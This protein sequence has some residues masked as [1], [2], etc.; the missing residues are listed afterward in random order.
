MAL[1]NEHYQP[2]GSGT[3]DLSLVNQFYRKG[4]LPMKL[5]FKKTR[6]WGP[7]AV[8]A[9]LLVVL[10]TP[11]ALAIPTTRYWVGPNPN[12]NWTTA[13][14]WSFTPPL[15]TPGAGQPVAGDD[16]FLTNTSSKTAKLNTTT[17]LLNSVTVDAVGGT[18]TLTQTY[19]PS[20]NLSASAETIGL[21]GIGVYNQNAG[22]N[23]VGSAAAENLLQPAR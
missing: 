5:A 8:I 15:G 10:L 4:E 1:F 13:N 22:N 9:A 3:W 17:P 7:L 14:N 21:N 23:T 6:Y 18:F 2:L 16:A 19:F 12:T 11:P 20:G